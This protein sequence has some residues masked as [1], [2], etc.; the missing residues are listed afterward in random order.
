MK[1]KPTKDKPILPARPGLFR[2][3]GRLW[4]ERQMREVNNDFIF[5]LERDPEETLPPPTSK[6][7]H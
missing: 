5:F 4:H 1:R 6:V 7:L 3:R 2:F